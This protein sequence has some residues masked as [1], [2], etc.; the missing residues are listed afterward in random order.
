MELK[1]CTWIGFPL[2]FWRCVSYILY[3][4]NP[5]HSASWDAILHSCNSLLPLHIIKVEAKHML[6]TSI[7]APCIKQQAFRIVSPYIFPIHLLL[8]WY[9]ACG[10][11]VAAITLNTLYMT[12]CFQYIWRYI[13]THD[14]QGLWKI[15]FHCGAIAE[16]HPACIHSLIIR[17]HIPQLMGEG[18]SRTCSPGGNHHAIVEPF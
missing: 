8:T 13:H 9:Y 12:Q 15:A 16:L 17:V 10:N 11:I 18:R 4:R 3:C 6:H 7:H 2:L 1:L 14:I 5:F